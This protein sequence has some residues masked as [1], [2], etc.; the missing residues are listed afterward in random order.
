MRR[1]IVLALVLLAPIAAAAPGATGNVNV[2]AGNQELVITW[3]PVAGAVDYEVYVYGGGHLVQTLTANATTATFRGVNERSYAIEVAAR[4]A[5]GAEGPRSE[6]VAATP[7]L[8]HDQ[9][10]LALGL[11]VLWSGVWL[12]ALLL[13]RTERDLRN[14][15]DRL[16]E[17]DPR[18]G[19]PR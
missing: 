18:P 19:G 5:S 7:S 12:Y 4:D 11:I 15:L 1:M 8:R 3:D 16:L 14:R 17:G 9:T 2:R 10:Y 6:P 13:A